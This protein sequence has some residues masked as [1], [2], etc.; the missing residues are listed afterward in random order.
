MSCLQ[1]IQREATQR[2]VFITPMSN[3]HRGKHKL[4]PNTMAQLFSLVYGR[5]VKW[6]AFNIQIQYICYQFGLQASPPF[7]EGLF[8][9]E[10]WGEQVDFRCVPLLC[11]DKPTHTR[12]QRCRMDD[13]VQ[14]FFNKLAIVL[15][16]SRPASFACLVSGEK[17][18]LCSI[19]PPI[20]VFFGQVM[21]C[22]LSRGASFCISAQSILF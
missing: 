8:S 22:L 2:A 1:E 21:L 9:I 19:M 6:S 20:D 18:W 17:R 11:L 13:I 10:P 7:Q 15:L 12:R 5:G 3:N 14:V 4:A 16:C